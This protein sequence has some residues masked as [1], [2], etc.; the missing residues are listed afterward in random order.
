MGHTRD[1]R[2]D[3][4]K[5][6]YILALDSGSA[7]NRA[8][9][10]N[11]EG[12][13]C[14]YAEKKIS[15]Y[16][17]HEGWVEQDPDEIWSTQLFVARKAIKLAHLE[18]SEIAAIAVTNQRETTIVWDARTGRPI[19]PAISWQSLQTG[20]ICK[21]LLKEGY[22]E[23]IWQK[24]SLVIAPYFS[25]TKLCW[26]FEHVPGARE[27]AKQGHLR[28][29]T[30]DT[31][32]MWKLSGG[33]IFATDYSNASRTMLF[34]IKD[35]TWDEDILEALGIPRKILPDVYP[36]SYLYGETA[37]GWLGAR[38]PIAACIGNQQADLFGEACFKPGE[39]KNS[40]GVG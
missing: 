37:A 1:L 16:T 26:I 31:W 15:T 3:F 35:L 10:F 18:P 36:S 17:P 28:F 8:V 11:R 38:I 2:G 34:H 12:Q 40:Y 22:R 4:L 33:E 24:T 29:G 39:A 13:I 7:K 25:G 20:E 27:L 21:R 30:V 9:I 5:K 23:E 19:Y 14:S 32:L 6:Q